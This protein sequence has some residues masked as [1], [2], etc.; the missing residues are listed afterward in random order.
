MERKIEL[1]ISSK[2]KLHQV[3][4]PGNSSLC[5]FCTL[6][7]WTLSLGPLFFL[8][9][10]STCMQLVVLSASYLLIAFW[11]YNSISFC[12]LII[13]F[14]LP[15][16]YHQQGKTTPL[17]LCLE[18]SSFQY[19]ESWVI[20]FAFHIRAGQS[21]SKLSTSEQVL[22]YLQFL[23][24]CSSFLTKSIPAAHLKPMC[25]SAVFSW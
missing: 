17:I 24:R 21:S 3:S 6:R 1:S 8:I 14:F 11:W 18:M 13:Y 25:L 9:K 22:P 23:I 7:P 2:S 5:L 19:P 16:Y 15:F 4:R 12:S 20:R 10:S